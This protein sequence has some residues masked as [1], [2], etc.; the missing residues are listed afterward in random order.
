[1][2]EFRVVLVRK[3][4]PGTAGRFLPTALSSTILPNHPPAGGFLASE[5]G[6]LPC[7]GAQHC[8]PVVPWCTATIPY[9]PVP[10]GRM[11][12]RPCGPV[13]TASNATTSPPSHAGA[14]RR[15]HGPTVEW[16]NAMHAELL[17]QRDRCKLWLQPVC[18]ATGISEAF[19]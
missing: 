9:T 18:A 13:L 10:L 1:M 7:L 19:G 4:G 11:P 12:C 5:C 16:D 14:L 15:P 8:F 17:V 2:I 3:A 6:D